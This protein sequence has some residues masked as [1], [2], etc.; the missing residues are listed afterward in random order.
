MYNFSEFCKGKQ[1][2]HYREWK[3]QAGKAGMVRCC[4]LVGISFYIT[5][6]PSDCIHLEEIQER[7]KYE[8]E[9]HIMWTKLNSQALRPGE[10]LVFDTR[11]DK[12]VSKKPDDVL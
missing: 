12:W 1:C 5:T 9:K 11:R 7:E 3:I 2:E 8:N 4:N 10:Y 6:Y